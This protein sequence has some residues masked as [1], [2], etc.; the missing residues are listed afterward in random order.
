MNIPDI[1]ELEN[2][3]ESV[4]RM[5]SWKTYW[6]NQDEYTNALKALLSACQLLCDVSDKMGDM[7]DLAKAELEL[8]HDSPELNLM[9]GYNSAR[10]EDIL[11]L[12]KKLMGIE[13][14]LW[15]YLKD[16]EIGKKMNGRIDCRDLATAIIQSFGLNKEG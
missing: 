15:N 8:E 11:W 10:V 12:T 2:A 4:K 3:M 1:P 9:K 7:N 14:V 13:E 16:T 6:E 5:L